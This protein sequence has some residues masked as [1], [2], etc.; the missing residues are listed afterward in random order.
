MPVTVAPDTNPKIANTGAKYTSLNGWSAVYGTGSE[1]VIAVRCI[2]EWLDVDGVEVAEVAQ[3]EF[4]IKTPD[5]E[6]LPVG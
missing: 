3:V 5:I 1:E 2:I 4:A 6:K